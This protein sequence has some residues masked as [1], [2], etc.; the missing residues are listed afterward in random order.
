MLRSRDL[1]GQFVKIVI[2]NLLYDKNSTKILYFFVRKN[3]WTNEFTNRW[4]TRNGCKVEM[5]RTH[6]PNG[7]WKLFVVL[8][9]KQII[10]NN[11]GVLYLIWI[12][13][14]CIKLKGP[15]CLQQSL[16][17]AWTL[18]SHCKHVMVRDNGELLN[19]L[20]F[21]IE[22]LMKMYLSLKITIFLLEEREKYKNIR[23][24]G[25]KSRLNL[26]TNN[27]ESPKRKV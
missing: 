11:I 25:S 20:C 21:S 4:K 8:F 13:L 3:G 5:G 26:H 22:Q 2:I 10:T 18:T 1:V 12:Q 9:K 14:S 19:S 15:I 27:V 16:F 24:L 6:H 7:K 17:V 23:P